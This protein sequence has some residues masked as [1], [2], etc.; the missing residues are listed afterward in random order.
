MKIQRCVLTFLLMNVVGVINAAE[1]KISSL[2]ELADYASKSGN[3]ITLSPGVYPLTDYLSVDSMAARHDSKQFQFITFSG[4]ENV[5]KLDGVEIEVDNELRSAL[6]APL[7]NSEFLITGSNNTFSGLTI[8][9]KGEGTT[10]GSAAF[11]VGGKDN[12]LKNITLRVKGSFPYGYGD[13]LGKGPKSVVKHKKHSGLLITGT[14]TKLYACNVFMRSLGHAFFIQGGSNTYFED[15]YAEGQIRPTDQMLAEVSGPAFEHDFASVYRNYDGKKTIPSGYMKSLNECGFRTYATGKVTAINCTAKYMR[16]G[17]ALAKAS[18][19]NCEAIDCE[20]GYY[21]NNAVAKDCR[22]DAKYGPLMYLVGNN[23]QID[24]TL[25]PGESDMKVH[26]VATICGSGHNVSI[27][28]SDQGTRKKE[29]P[30]MLGYG[31]PSAGEISS[32]IPEAAAKNITITNTT[33]MPIVIG[34][35][36]TDCEI[37]THGPIL[38]NKGSNINVAKTI[39]D[40]EICRVAWET[41]CGSKIAGVYKTDCFNYVH[42]AKGIPNVL[43]YGDSISIKYTSAVQKNLEGQATVFR[44]FKNGGSSDHFIPNMEKMHDAMFQPGLEGGWDFKWDLIHFNV[45]LHDL[46]YL[47][48]GNL[49]KK[50]GKQVSSISVYKENLD[51]ICKWLRSMFPNAKLIF[52]T[53]TPVPAN[54]KGRF[55]GDSI[56]FNNAA[57]EVL[58]KY[59][60]IIINDL[61]TFT[62]PNI[63]EWAQEPGNV[64]YNELGFNAQGKEVARIIAENL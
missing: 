38:E 6:K 17:F 52:S 51:G 34:E 49:N 57:R 27:K 5:F 56:K 24:L 41:L 11:A 16:V 64:H 35:K 25:M 61:Y 63:E 59:P 12:V 23:S 32:P 9:Y 45:G 18:L 44:L 28:N 2:K 31:M 22:G 62:K 10:F 36:A 14:N 48:N 7:H 58:A 54:A 26:A 29:T 30:I 50:E 4:N 37:K 15:C 60:D 1:V 46:K 19:S 53:T 3:V 39:S 13:Y 33:S 55:E 42:P 47:K 21:L 40:K 20:R 43:L 8:R